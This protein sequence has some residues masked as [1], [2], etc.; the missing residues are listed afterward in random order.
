VPPKTDP[1]GSPS[2]ISFLSLLLLPPSLEELATAQKVMAPPWILSPAHAC[3]RSRA[4]HRRAVPRWCPLAQARGGDIASTGCSV[5]SST[6]RRTA[7]RCPSHTAAV[8]FPRAGKA[9]AVVPFPRNGGI[10]PARRRCF[11]PARWQQRRRKGEIQGGP[12]PFQSSFL[13]RVWS[14]LSRFEIGCSFF[15]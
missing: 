3:S 7:A 13:V 15:S 11:L 12:S 9:A 4:R 5:P 14:C 6:C 10:C 8:S 1:A 2:S